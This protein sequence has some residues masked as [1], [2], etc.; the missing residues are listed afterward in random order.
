[1]QTGVHVRKRDRERQRDRETGRER[2][3]RENGIFEK[4]IDVI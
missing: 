2:A 3:R 1:V 4:C